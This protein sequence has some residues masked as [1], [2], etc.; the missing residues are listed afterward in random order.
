MAVGIRHADHVATSIHKKLA[1]T[2]PTSGGRSAG[3][4][5]SRTQAMEFLNVTRPSLILYFSD[6]FPFTCTSL[7]LSFKEHQLSFL[8]SN[9]LA[10]FMT[11]FVCQN[12]LGALRISFFI[13]HLNHMADTD[14][15]SSKETKVMSSSLHH[16]LKLPVWSG[17][18]LR[19]LQSLR[20][21]KRGNLCLG[22]CAG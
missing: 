17:L 10:L 18:S 11:C 22:R 5:R 7:F 4:V 20:G 8:L 12:R 19:P 14:Q 3:L 16:G 2:S 1:I 13:Q 15:D 9:I 6:I 21:K